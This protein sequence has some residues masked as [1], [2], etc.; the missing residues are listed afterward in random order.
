MIKLESACL[1]MIT[2]TRGDLNVSGS[3]YVDVDGD[4][5]VT[6]VDVTL[7]KSADAPSASTQLALLLEGVPLKLNDAILRGKLIDAPRALEV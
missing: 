5:M 2:T 1:V 6:E 7:A 4:R 3:V